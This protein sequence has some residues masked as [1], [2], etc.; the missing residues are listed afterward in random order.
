M[1]ALRC[2]TE[3][4]VALPCQ[5]LTLPNKSGQACLVFP[6]RANPRPTVPGHVAPDPAKTR[7]AMPIRS[8]PAMSSLTGPCRY[9]PAVPER[10]NS[11]HAKHCRSFPNPAMAHVAEAF[12]ACRVSSLLAM[13][14]QNKPGPVSPRLAPSL[15]FTPAMYR[16][17]RRRLTSP[18]QIK[19][20]RIKPV[21]ACLVLP[22]RA[23]TIFI[24]PCHVTPAVPSHARSVRDTSHLTQPRRDASC[25][26]CVVLSDRASP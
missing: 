12:Q 25:L 10:N 22:I 3:P 17:A 7:R 2:A 9:T 6:G 20:C 5:G 24:T 16:V 13:S 11:N 18:C 19:Q 8:R 26:P 23:E 15:R 14:R 1:P 21:R 4:S